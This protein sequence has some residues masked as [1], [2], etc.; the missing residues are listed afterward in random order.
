[1]NNDPFKKSRIE[2]DSSKRARIATLRARA[3]TH[4]AAF[5]V[6]A[7]LLSVPTA[8]AGEIHIPSESDATGKKIL[9]TPQ[10]QDYLRAFVAGVNAKDRKALMALYD[11]ASQAAMS[12]VKPD[13]LDDFFENIFDTP[14][15]ANYSAV[16]SMVGPGDSLELEDMGSVYAVRPAAL[17]QVNFGSD[18]S[19]GGTVLYIVP[20]A[21]KWRSV[22]A[23]PPDPA[24]LDAAMAKAGFHKEEQPAQSASPVTASGV[25]D[26]QHDAQP[27]DESTKPYRW[28]A[29]LTEADSK[30]RKYEV[31]QIDQLPDG[32]TK[33]KVVVESGMAQPDHG[34]YGLQVGLSD[35]TTAGTGNVAE[36]FGLQEDISVSCVDASNRPTGVGAS[37][38]V[39][40]P[41]S[42]MAGIDASPNGTPLTD[43]TLR[44][45]RYHST[46]AKGGAYV[47]DVVLRV[48]DAGK[49]A[50]SK[51]Q[52]QV[53]WREQECSNP[54]YLPD[55]YIITVDD[56][57]KYRVFQEGSAPDDH[58]VNCIRFT[59]T[60]DAALDPASAP[61]ARAVPFKI[62]GQQFQWRVFKT[63]ASGRPVIRKELVIP[64]I[65]PRTK[66]D[67]DS[68]F[69]H[70]QVDAETQM[71]IDTLT[72][73]AGGILR[74]SLGNHEAAR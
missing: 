42:T 11:P 20:N 29:H 7:F 33:T 12:K 49:A 66:Q 40:L 54:L 69:I 43:G 24:K 16:V 37:A 8:R 6:M 30:D 38:F 17:L 57:G 2:A 64:N 9:A 58:Q 44:F 32:T 41:G 59:F 55:G 67:K 71:A 13:V 47:T 51:H 26:F 15:P 74:D 34:A 52:S 46:D 73:V 28:V 39:S 4:W 23:S 19:S 53:Q 5:L 25:T 36:M 61:G 1:M 31:V 27:K 50:E 18:N 70:V 22:W 35:K 65:L 56:I 72:P 68:G 63:Q 10:F 3:S 60:S 21:G 62:K 45:A 48:A 14:I